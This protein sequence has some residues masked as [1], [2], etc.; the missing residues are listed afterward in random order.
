MIVVIMETL[1]ALLTL[2]VSEYS[3]DF[4]HKYQ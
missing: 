2:C 3:D 4:Q 1:S